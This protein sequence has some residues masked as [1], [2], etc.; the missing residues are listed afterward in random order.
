MIVDEYAKTVLEIVADEH[1]GVDDYMVGLRYSI[2]VVGGGKGHKAGL[3]IV[4]VEDVL[5][6]PMA[7]PIIELK[8]IAEHAS[9]TNIIEKSLG[10][11]L[12]NAIS[13]YILLDMEYIEEYR[14]EQDK[15]LIEL[16]LEA[17][18]GHKDEKIVVVGNMVPLVKK[19]REHGFNPIVLERNPAYRGKSCLPDSSGYRELLD[20]DITIITGATL[21]NDTI[22]IVLK[23][24]EKA[25]IKILAGPTAAVYPEPFFD[26]G[27]THIASTR[28]IDIQK[29]FNIIKHGGGRW[30]LDEYLEDYIIVAE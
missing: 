2:G 12:L 17:V 8:D 20:A 10:I 16:V 23:L 22:D 5:G 28:I 27:I 13:Q 11:A 1:L 15:S 14:V 21:V 30:D 7:R 29:A 26:K 4:P 24:A 18:R 9:S 3:A 25:K 19:L 6:M